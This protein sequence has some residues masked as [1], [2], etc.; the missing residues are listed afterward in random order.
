MGRRLTGLCPPVSH[1][2]GLVISVLPLPQW[3]PGLCHT[4][5]RKS[6][7]ESALRAP[8]PFGD[9]GHWQHTRPTLS[10]PLGHA[11]GAL[12]LDAHTQTSGRQ[13]GA[14]LERGGKAGL[15][16]LQAAGVY[17]ALAAMRL[18]PGPGARGLPAL[19]QPLGLC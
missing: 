6:F 7:C 10:P 9:P 1:L 8:R 18:E 12:P 4:P 5:A 3:R 2:W 13:P 15:A 16:G 19:P 17:R 14:S 11:E